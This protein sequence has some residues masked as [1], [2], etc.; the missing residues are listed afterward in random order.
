MA[1]SVIPKSLEG[2]EL[3]P[4][5]HL[6]LLLKEASQALTL[7]KF[8]KK[9]KRDDTVYTHFSRYWSAKILKLSIK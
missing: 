7:Q 1:C 6:L 9:K 2:A 8:K 4:L 3:S 5:D